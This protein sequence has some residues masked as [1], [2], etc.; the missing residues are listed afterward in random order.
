MLGE[1]FEGNMY[2]FNNF[3]WN[4]TPLSEA[5]RFRQ[6]RIAH[7][8]KEYIKDHPNQGLHDE[9]AYDEEDYN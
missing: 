7:Y 6:P 5:I 8:L 2:V 1:T 3:R 4:N 9:Y